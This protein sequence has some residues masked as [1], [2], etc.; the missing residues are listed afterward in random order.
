MK[1]YSLFVVLMLMV[2]CFASAQTDIQSSQSDLNKLRREI[3]QIEK[4]IQEKEK[5]EKATLDLL[6]QYDRQANLIRKLIKA[7]H[8]KERDLENDIEATRRSIRSLTKQ[9][10]S[11][12]QQYAKYVTRLYKYGRSHDLEL[13]L[14][15]KSF[16]QSL[17]R[18]EYLRRFSEQRKK[19]LSNIVLQRDEIEKENIKLNQQLDEQ[20]DFIKQ[21]KKEENTLADNVKKRRKA[22][23]QVR[24]DKNNLQKDANRITADAKKLEQLIAKLIEAER[25]RKLREEELAKA[26]KQP[27]PVPSTTGKS[28]VNL[29]RA[30]PWP[31]ASGKIIGRFGNQQNKQLGTVT[32]NT[33]IDVAVPV[34][35]Q[36]TSV[37]AGEVSLI[38]WL[39]S[40][41]NLV[42]VDHSDGF[43]TV[44]AHL[45][46]IS[47]NE[48][49]KVQQ[50]SLLGRSGESV[51]GAVLHFEVWKDRE[52]Q[53]P[54]QWLNPRGLNTR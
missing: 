18:S 49:E 5:K 12:K 16:N 46:E 25:V 13:L 20:Q 50:K 11:L 26:N 44:Y 17:I 45:S 33:G 35:T 53:N 43:R 10:T 3:E 21:K 27:P 1:S 54:E 41:G 7:L 51:E 47:V 15:S 30:L 2:V 19:D 29:R 36:V 4:K 14:A 32:Q 28:F 42:I 24:K 39:P 48:G 8:K 31:V 6:D 22:L 38:S 52:K 23:A 37:A 40:F 9:L 34:G